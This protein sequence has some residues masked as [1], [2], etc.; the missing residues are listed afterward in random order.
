MKW[1]RRGDYRQ[2]LQTLAP[3]N[4]AEYDRFV[5]IDPPRFQDHRHRP[6]GHPSASKNQVRIRAISF[7]IVPLRETGDTAYQAC[8]D[9]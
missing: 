9:A 2:I 4:A 7:A 6:L 5:I 1:L 8:D 3:T